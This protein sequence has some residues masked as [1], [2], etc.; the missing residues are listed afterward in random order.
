MPFGLR[1]PEANTREAPVAGSIS[2]IAARRSSFSMPRSAT[3]LFEPTVTY[4]R[5]PSALAI[6]FLVQ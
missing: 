2:R 6:R 3:L 4:S 1:N 5:L